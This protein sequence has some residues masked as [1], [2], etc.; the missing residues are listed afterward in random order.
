MR[1]YT[2]AEIVR[3]TQIIGC[4]HC[5][6][7]GSSQLTFAASL[8]AKV[9]DIHCQEVVKRS[10]VSSIVG[11][12]RLDVGVMEIPRVK[13]SLPGRAPIGDPAL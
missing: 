2:V 4:R 1:H 9:V 13:W 10:I 8:Q 6:Y 5:I 11:T 3:D 12:R 7:A